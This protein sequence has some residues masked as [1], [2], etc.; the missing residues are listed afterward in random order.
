KGVGVAIAVENLILRPI[1]KQ[2]WK[3]QWQ[4]IANNVIGE[5]SDVL[6]EVIQ[7]ARLG[8]R[9][10]LLHSLHKRTMSIALQFRF[11]FIETIKFGE[12]FV[13]QRVK[14]KQVAEPDVVEQGSQKEN[15]QERGFQK[16]LQFAGF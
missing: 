8:F 15:R 5:E 6:L 16:S 9:S 13:V 2:M 12:A 11:I 14:G 1:A 4:R 10:G 3:H 7:L